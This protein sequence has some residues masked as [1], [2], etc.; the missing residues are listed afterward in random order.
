MPIR[1]QVFCLFVF[2]RLF[3][4]EREREQ[5]WEREWSGGENPD[6]RN[7]P[8][9]S[10][11][12]KGPSWQFDCKKGTPLSTTCSRK[13]LA[14]ENL[15]FLAFIS[16]MSPKLLVCSL[17]VNQRWSNVPEDQLENHPG[18]QK[19]HLYRTL[20]SQRLSQ[21]I[22]FHSIKITLLSNTQE[23]CWNESDSRWV[24]LPSICE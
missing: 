4:F 11:S 7:W 5:E 24:P 17:P 12:H 15:L 21:P 13:W 3:V 9:Q 8:K 1:W 6:V 10:A 16:R 22:L 14:T 19:S 20:S 23:P 2:V 18:F